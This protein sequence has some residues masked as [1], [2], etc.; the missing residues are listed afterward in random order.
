MSAIVAHRFSRCLGLMKMGGQVGA[1]S[2]LDPSVSQSSSGVGSV[3]CVWQGNR[4]R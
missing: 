4:R 2:S 1:I 3:M